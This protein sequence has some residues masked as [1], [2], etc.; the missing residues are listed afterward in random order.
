MIIS[1]FIGLA[2][3]CISSFLHDK[4]PKAFHK[5]VKARSVTMDMQRNKLIH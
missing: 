3:E 5:A 1:G 2:F 4:R